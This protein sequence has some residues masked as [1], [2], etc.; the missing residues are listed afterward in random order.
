[1][2]TYNDNEFVKIFRKMLNWE[3]YTDVNTKTLFLHCLLKANWKAGSWHGYK[4]EKGQFV[5]SLPSLAKETG[6]SV[7]E[8]RTA[9]NHLKSTGELTDWHDNKVRIITVVAYT[10]YQKSDRLNVS[11]TT[12]KRQ[13]NDRQATADIRTYKNNK[14]NKENNTPPA[15]LS[16]DITEDELQKLYAELRE[17]G[18]E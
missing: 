8:V 16:D 3:W 18:Y 7:R 17:E 5:T 2:W 11:P 9:L 4:Y 1:M 15:D 6:L 12:D 13:T 10:G 14:N